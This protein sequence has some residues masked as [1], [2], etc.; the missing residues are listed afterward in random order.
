MTI[1]ILPTQALV[2]NAY[3]VLV[4]A[5]PG[6]A[7]FKEHQAFINT[8]GVGS[9][10]YKAALESFLSA[11]PT[12]TL[13]ATM[14]TN[15]GLTT[16]TVAQAT[17]FLNANPGNRAG[18]MIDLAAQ[19]YNYSG[20][21]AAL[22]TAKT[23][24]VANITNS[25][26]FS[27]NIAN[28]TGQSI[29]GP[30][31]TGITPALTVGFD[32]LVGTAFADTFS[33]RTIGN[34]NTLND[35]DR[36]D[37]GA[38]NDTVYVDFAASNGGLAITPAF[39]NVETVV[40]RAQ[41]IPVDATNGNNVSSNV[42]INTVQIDAQRSLDVNAANRVIADLGVTRWESNNSRSD[43][44]I[45]DVR[46]GNTQKTKDVTI[47]MVET[48][49]GNVDFAVY[50]DQLSL[51]NSGGGTSSLV[52]RIMDTG[53][54]AAATTAAT[55][56]LNNPYDQFKIGVNG[57]LQTISLNTTAAPATAANA[58][59]YA[60]LLTAFQTALAV[61]GTATAA[62][63]ADFS[64]IDPLSGATV[65]GK[66]IV[67]TGAA[68]FTFS[69]VAG[70]GWFNTTGAAV[71]NNSNIYT[72]FTTGSTSVSELVT[73]TV[74]LDDVGRGSTGGDLVIGGLSA[75]QTSTS[76]G[77]E[78]FEITVE[79]NS[80]LQTINSTNNALREVTIKNAPG[81][82]TVANAYVANGG[83]LT[84]N[85][86]AAQA[87]AS[88]QGGNNL[89]AGVE[90][91]SPAGTHHGAGA[92]GFADV[93]LI[94]GSAMTGNLA[95]TASV[96]LDS[97][98]KYV[99]RTDGQV[100]PAADIAGIGNVNFNVPGA[101][102]AY[103]GGSGNDTI[104]TTIDGAVAASRSSIVSGQS[105][106]TFNIQG[107]AGNDAITVNL[108]PGTPLVGGLQ[109]WAN[110]QDLNNNITISGGAGND[111][112]RTPGAGDTVIDAG[113][114][115]DTVYTDNS[116]RQ[117]TGELLGAVGIN[118]GTTTSNGVFVFNTFDQA[119]AIANGA[120]RNVSDLRSGAND[121]YNFYKGTVTVAFKGLAAAAITLANATTY[122]TTDLEI[123]QAIKTAINTDAV[124]SKL[125]VAQDGPGNTLVVTSLIDGVMSTAD[126][127]VTFAAPAASTV[128]SG[129]EITGM[130]AAYANP[131]ITTN[132]LALTAA[133]VLPS[134][135]RTDYNTAMGQDLNGANIV[136]AASTSTSDNFVTPGAGN[137]VI[138]LGTT[139]GVDVARSSNEVVTLT[140]G[141]GDD[142]VVN[143]ATAGNGADHI[144]VASFLNA[145]APVVFNALNIGAN[146]V[147]VVLEDAVVGS[148]T[149]NNT[150]ALVTALVR[151]A[152]T[153]VQT[154][155]SKAVF[156]V[157]KGTVGT[158]Y[159]ITNGTA[160]AD[161]VVAREGSINLAQADWNLLTAASFTAPSAQAEG[162]SSAPI[163]AA[164]NALLNNQIL[165]GTTGIDTLS[166]NGFTG[167]TLTGGASAD[168]FTV[169][170]LSTG[171]IITDLTTGDNVTVAGTGVVTANNVAAFVGTA[172]TVN[173]GG[174]AGAFI[175]NSLAAGSTIDMSLA[176]GTVGYTLQ[177]AAG[178]D[179]LTG[180]AL[181]DTLASGA[182]G[183]DVLN[184]GAGN[185]T[186]SSGGGTVT[187]NGGTGDDTI[188]GGAG[189]DTIN[190]TAGTDTVTA[191]GTGADVI[192]VSAGAVAN[193]TTNAVFTATAASSNSGNLAF[194]LGAAGVYNFALLGGTAGIT[195]TG[196]AGADTITGTV[197]ADTI[198]TGGGVDTVTGGAGVDTITLTG[199]VIETVKIASVGANGVDRDVVNTFTA[200]A[201][202]DV[203]NFNSGIAV[204]TGTNDF[205]AA[206]SLQNHGAAGNLVVLAATEL[207]TVA[208]ATIADA[209]SANSLNGTNLLT[210]IGG[211]L[212]GAIAGQNN[213]LVAV[214]IAGGS[215]AL[216]YASSADNAII[217]SEITLVGVVNGVAIGGF[218]VANFT[219]GA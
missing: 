180:S 109:N 27:N 79:D 75:G 145:G 74:V 216:Y 31:T 202:G 106:F 53:A 55:P 57:A 65:V 156:I 15:L 76:R 32:N 101:N 116:G 162:A 115:E 38:G 155:A 25:F 61:S 208:S 29:A 215:T 82:N 166:T 211:T 58:D 123:N 158:V 212:T 80:K 117:N 170:N 121:S 133:S 105:D 87:G 78:R 11:T 111:T 108:Q 140:A 118:V 45:E 124:L 146:S 120:A 50:F 84:V 183:T 71:P 18:A 16:F 2:L 198:T 119:N 85:G 178:N 148:A 68:G 60:Q 12:A 10:G 98:A 97:I 191:F 17:A 122:K 152:D 175:I 104:V 52:I 128:F 217:A 90:D 67:L 204:L 187:F 188:T 143:F 95:F 77:V 176:T 164:L 129:A 185:D 197:L 184:G 7:A 40:I 54:A 169:T 149:A 92:A 203:L 137:D 172:A 114:G 39:K 70:S 48:D 171:S 41:G 210:A 94:D 161:T 42:G 6:N 5:T 49:P 173:N 8:T 96:S 126:L 131:L 69:S 56:L 186:M 125:L 64:V 219:N 103:A 167:V 51:R 1:L 135:G 163:A 89:L 144:S 37:G 33:A 174:G 91:N 199:G 179:V 83:A 157:V 13:A 159:S 43:V 213:I 3:A 141:F 4:G 100:N 22:L 107:G 19:L 209:T 35:G 151:A 47:A 165:V 88:S 192:V 9:N 99:T 134:A 214:G 196:N 81:N 14:L 113:E 153:V 44:V 201:G 218:T 93:R 86:D 182:T 189:I 20:T 190:V 127:T 112:I 21:D 34:V 154:T 160:I 136:G 110:N 59:T 23:T 142:T 195:V 139:V 177:G 206:A 138:V 66:E 72:L 63:G 62:L 102:F 132:A 205:A 193:V 207:V 150:L 26:N 147:G 28:V 36:I 30:V 130:A 168:V 24:Y 181:N 194:T 200:G 46:I 73:S